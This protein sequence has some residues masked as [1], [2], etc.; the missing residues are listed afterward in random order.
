MATSSAASAEMRDAE[1]NY[2]L[3][4]HEYE[5]YTPWKELFVEEID[6]NGI[7]SVSATI[8]DNQHEVEIA[9]PLTFPIEEGGVSRE[10]DL[11][12][13]PSPTTASLQELL[14]LAYK[15]AQIEGQ[16]I[17]PYDQHRITVNEHD[18]IHDPYMDILGEIEA[19]TSPAPLAHIS[20]NELTMH[21][22]DCAVRSATPLLETFPHAENR[23]KNPNERNERFKSGLN[24][25]KEK[26]RTH[27][28]FTKTLNKDKLIISFVINL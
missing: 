25:L 16:E 28:V 27:K 1:A 19:S 13:P 7:D 14:E 21:L 10:R 9:E 22:S 11:E 18:D 23:M 26:V 2:H 4:D 15:E 24:Y 3:M 20:S 12:N 5:F 17:I 6:P 8:L